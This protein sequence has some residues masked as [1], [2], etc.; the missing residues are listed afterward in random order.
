MNNVK[1]AF[2]E[3]NDPEIIAK[4]LKNKLETDTPNLTILF[5]SS[6]YPQEEIV[7]KFKKVLNG[8]IF[9]CS[10]AGE[11]SSTGFHKN[12]IVALGMKAPKTVLN[13]NTEIGKFD[14]DSEKVGKETAEKAFSNLKSGMDLYFLKFNNASAIE[15]LRN[16]PFYMLIASDGLAGNEESVL[17]GISKATSNR[18]QAVGGSAGDDLKF[19]KTFVYSEKDVSSN[20]VSIAA[21]YTILKVGVGIKMGFRPASLST[22]YGVVTENGSSERIVKTINN[23]PARDVYMKWVEKDSIEDA[24]KSFAEN[25]LGIVLPSTKMWKVRSPAR[26]L[27]DGSIQFYSNVSPKGIGIGLLE[28]DR[29][30]HINAMKEAVQEAI[31]RAGNPKKIHAVILFDCILRGILSDIYE[32]KDDEIKEVKNLVGEDVP[33]IGFLTYGEFGNTDIEPLWHHNQTVTAMIIGE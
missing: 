6:N 1:F 7:N 19:E 18:I 29:Q 16:F 23:K 11:I 25:P 31:E 2:S 12:S 21:L 26:F 10:T 27:D 3:G 22:K 33:I 28:S 24:N 15:T 9:G 17:R 4:D 5:A 8:S 30:T 13:V 20:A 32:T 14:K